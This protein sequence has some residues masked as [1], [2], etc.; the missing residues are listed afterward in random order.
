MQRRP[1]TRI[2]KSLFQ[3]GALAS[4]WILIAAGAWVA[5]SHPT[6]SDAQVIAFI[7]V[8]SASVPVIAFLESH[9]G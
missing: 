6:S 5:F 7:L 3:G 1:R 2:S 8:F 9:W 4:A